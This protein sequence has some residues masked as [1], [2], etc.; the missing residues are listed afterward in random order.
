MLAG[1]ALHCLSTLSPNPFRKGG[2]YF[3]IVSRGEVNL[4]T[5]YGNG[6]MTEPAVLN[7]APL[8]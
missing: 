5:S 6:S 8:H 4:E 2:G 7:A 1:V 3:E